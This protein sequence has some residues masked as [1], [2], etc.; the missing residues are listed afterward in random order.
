MRE[1]D[2]V[3]K[4]MAAVKRLRPNAVIWKL[5][6]RYTRGLPDLLIL[7]PGFRIAWSGS[8]V[9]GTEGAT[10]IFAVEC[11]ARRGRLEKL[12]AEQGKKLASLPGC[13]WVVARCVEDV[14][15]PIRWLSSYKDKGNSN[16]GQ[17]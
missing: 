6:D 14:T 13:R 11:K 5:S 17:D 8:V 4:I 7:V 2:L 3:R 16:H 1:A 10:H 15:E 9:K 12:Q